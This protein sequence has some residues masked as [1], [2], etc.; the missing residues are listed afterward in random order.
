MEHPDY[1]TADTDVHLPADN[2]NLCVGD[3]HSHWSKRQKATTKTCF[4]ALGEHSQR[5]IIQ[6]ALRDTAP[7]SSTRSRHLVTLDS[8]RPSGSRGLARRM[9]LAHAEMC[10]RR[11][12]GGI[13]S[14][15]KRRWA[16]VGRRSNQ[17]QHVHVRFSSLELALIS[18]AKG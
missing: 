7:T 14:K 8:R 16:H 11:R 1:R 3:I 2:S 17:F 9:S 5:A 12:A 6:T 18:L 4:T 10:H 15:N 13:V